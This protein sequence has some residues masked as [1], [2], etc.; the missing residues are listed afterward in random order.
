MRPI[1]REAHKGRGL[2]AEE[3]LILCEDDN[4]TADGSSLLPAL[5]LRE[6]QKR[7][8]LLRHRKAL[9]ERTNVGLSESV[10]PGSASANNWNSCN[11][12]PLSSLLLQLGC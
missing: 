8:H 10:R 11:R 5:C 3:I 2:L 6:T 9:E 12:F 1:H 7:I 4:G